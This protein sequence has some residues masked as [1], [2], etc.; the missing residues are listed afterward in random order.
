MKLAYLVDTDWTIHY[1]NG[2]KE[3]V[4]RLATFKKDGLAISII[5][6]AELYEGI[7]YSTK[8]A[9]NEKGLDDFLTNVSILGI[10]EEICK[11]FGK[12]RGRMRQ[13]K[14]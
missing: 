11:V 8:P 2:H 12:E 13:E 10:D 1:L 4:E 6:L 5:S 7:Y 3:I 9:E 14:G